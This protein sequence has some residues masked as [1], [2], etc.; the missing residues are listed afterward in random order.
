[1][2]AHERASILFEELRPFLPSPVGHINHADI[3]TILWQAIQTDRDQV[4]RE[5]ADAIRAQ[6]VESKPTT[7]D[8]EIF[9]GGFY[10]VTHGDKISTGDGE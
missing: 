9:D 1:M 5:L 10:T 8:A 2:T 7:Q 6:L 4:R 3:M